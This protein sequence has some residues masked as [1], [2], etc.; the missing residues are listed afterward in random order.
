MNFDCD[1]CII[2]AGPVGSTISYYLESRKNFWILG[3]L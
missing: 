3:E 2:G 1:V